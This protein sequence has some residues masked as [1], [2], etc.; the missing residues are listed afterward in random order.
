MLDTPYHP[1]PFGWPPTSLL[2]G[3]AAVLVVATAFTPVGLLV[4]ALVFAAYVVRTAWGSWSRPAGS[5]S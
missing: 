4:W 5:G 2:E 3:P 1:R